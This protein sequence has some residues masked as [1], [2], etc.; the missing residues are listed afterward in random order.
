MLAPPPPTLF[1]T[2][3][4][5]D[6]MDILSSY[7]DRRGSVVPPRQVSEPLQRYQRGRIRSASCVGEGESCT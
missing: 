7:Y 2:A 1:E 4:V 6:P 5:D 3:S